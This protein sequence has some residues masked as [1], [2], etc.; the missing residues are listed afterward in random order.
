M[1][2]WN[3]LTDS[4]VLLTEHTKELDDNNFL[5]YFA[6]RCAVNAEAFYN[7]YRKS[8]HKEIAPLAG[9]ELGIYLG[10]ADMVNGD[11]LKKF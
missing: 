10:V 9:Q 4:S 8:I 6:A 3:L 7:A 11:V 2:K 5:W 1:N